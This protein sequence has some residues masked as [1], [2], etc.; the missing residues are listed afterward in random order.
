[1][2]WAIG[3][4]VVR[5]INSRRF[6]VIFHIHVCFCVSLVALVRVGPPQDSAPTGAGHAYEELSLSVVEASSNGRVTSSN[7]VIEGPVINEALVG[8]PTIAWPVTNYNRLSGG[9][10]RAAYLYL[11]VA[12]TSGAMD[13]KPA[14]A[15]V[16]AEYTGV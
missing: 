15:W 2:Q 13:F 1:M 7:K 10:R 12:H 9:T 3:G 14:T 8:Q 4:Q 16:R 11:S 5:I 6:M